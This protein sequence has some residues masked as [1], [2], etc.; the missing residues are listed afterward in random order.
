MHPLLLLPVPSSNWNTRISCWLRTNTCNSLNS[1]RVS[2]TRRSSC[3]YRMRSSPVYPIRPSDSA[4]LSLWILKTKTLC[5]CLRSSR[6]SRRALC[7]RWQ[8]LRRK[9]VGYLLRC[10]N[11]WSSKDRSGSRRSESSAMC[12][13]CLKSARKWLDQSNI[14]R[15][16]AAR[17]YK[18]LKICKYTLNP[19][20]HW[21]CSF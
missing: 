21:A 13:A 19:G 5:C 16:S 20:N 8:R 15:R 9:R 3:E 6:R 14:S 18:S 17:S 1:C 4:M 2:S 10:S 11:H 12:F 7:M